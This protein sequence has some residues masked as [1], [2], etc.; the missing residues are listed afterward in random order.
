[1]TAPPDDQVMSDLI[2]LLRTAAKRP[3]DAPWLHFATDRE[4]ELAAAARWL[5]SAADSP[6][7]KEPAHGRRAV[8]EWATLDGSAPW[9]ARISVP[10][11]HV[12]EGRVGR[13]RLRTARPTA[14][15]T[16]KA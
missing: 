10:G 3:P 7:A 5:L 14:R 11:V 6:I 2:P 9:T 15:S 8:I 1:M 4:A 16:R 12:P 13:V